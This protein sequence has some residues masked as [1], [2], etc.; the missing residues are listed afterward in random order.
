MNAF[1][2]IEENIKFPQKDQT[3]KAPIKK[4]TE[5]IFPLYLIFVALWFAKIFLSRSGEKYYSHS[6]QTSISNGK[7]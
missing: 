3:K 7:I 5:R 2:S 1:L 6:V 4:E